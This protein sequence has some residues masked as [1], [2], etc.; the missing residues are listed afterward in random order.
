IHFFLNTNHTENTLTIEYADNI[1]FIDSNIITIENQTYGEGIQTL[2][3]L[4]SNRSYYYKIIAEGKEYPNETNVNSFETLEIEIKASNII[5]PREASKT[6]SFT[7]FPDQDIYTY[8]LNCEEGLI[9]INEDTGNPQVTS[10]YVT[11]NTDYTCTLI[12]SDSINSKQTDFVITVNAGLVSYWPFNEGLGSTAYDS[13]SQNHGTLVNGPAWIT[14]ENECI[15]GA[16][17]SFDG[18]NDYVKTDSLAA[19][20]SNSFT[21][22]GWFYPYSIISAQRAV[23][24][25]HTSAGQNL[26]MVFL[27]N[28]NVSYYDDSTN[29]IIASESISKNRWYFLTVSISSNGNGILYLNGKSVASFNTTVRPENGG[30]FSIGQEWDDATATDFFNGLIDEVKI[31]SE[32]LSE[33]Q[34]KQEYFLY[35]AIDNINFKNIKSKSADIE[36]N[37]SKGA[38]TLTN[39]SIEYATDSLFNNSQTIN[40][41]NQEE[42][43][44]TQS[45]TN[46]TP[47]TEYFIRIKA[48]NDYGESKTFTSTFTSS[49]LATNITASNILTSTADI[50]FDL[51]TSSANITLEYADNIEFTNPNIIILENQTQGKTTIPLSN[52]IENTT[53]YY[54]INIVD[55][56]NYTYSYQNTFTTQTINLSVLNITAVVDTETTLSIN[57][58][59]PEQSYTY[60]WNCDGLDLTNPDTANPTFISSVVDTNYN[61]FVSASDGTNS[62]VKDF[63]IHI[64][65]NTLEVID[66]TGCVLFEPDTDDNHLYT[67]YKWTNIGEG[68]ITFLGEGQIDVLVV[69]GGGGGGRGGEGGIWGGGGGAGGL[70]FKEGYLI[71]DES[72][73]VF[74]G[75][76]GARASSRSYRGGSGE[77]SVF[78]SLVAFGGGGG[79]SGWYNQTTLWNGL[80]GGSGG[81]GQCYKGT[82][83]GKGFEG[84]GYDGSGSST[85]GG[86]GGGGGAGSTA[87]WIS[88]G[89]G[90]NVFGEVYAKGGSSKE[91]QHWGSGGAWANI[92]NSGNG[93]DGGTKDGW[94]SSGASGIVII[95]IPKS[96]SGIAQTTNSNYLASVNTSDLDIQLASLGI[97][98]NISLIILILIIGFIGFIKL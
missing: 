16:C 52:L 96:S 27:R 19:N 50:V 68:N 48:S 86:G 70:L 65:S 42:G 25:F 11:E 8:L 73:S 54:N 76:G 94:G 9:L 2:D 97:I 93:G 56:D 18:S 80:D 26:N 31:Y 46:L 87:L 98:N 85:T 21:F 47:E 55:L 15:S 40:L 75:K 32:A 24:S 63:L 22:S 49:P 17:L 1:E 14:D 30:K 37:L 38:S 36:F 39:I 90:V 66:C 13:W 35:R 72:I 43:L 29:H 69:G 83:G 64:T 10:P 7:V 53:Y 6:L 82:I 45:L 34:I 4:I 12:V 5:I 67:Y 79:G 57:T 51:N 78:G 95:R 33:S 60:L 28:T 41:Q 92:S 3:N 89:D 44:I 71:K 88:G 91:P 74:I 59:T 23:L 20:L 61:C 81:G 58:L 77:N 84:Q 62:T